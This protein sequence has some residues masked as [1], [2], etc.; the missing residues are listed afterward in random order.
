MIITTCN[1]RH[2]RS[3][4]MSHSRAGAWSLLS[5][6]RILEVFKK[7]AIRMQQQDI[8]LPLKRILIRPEAA[9]E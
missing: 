5:A 4:Q 2:R 8:A 6:L 9:G 1:D 7:L 3:S